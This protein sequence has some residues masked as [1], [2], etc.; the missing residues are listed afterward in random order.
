MRLSVDAN[1]TTV[2]PL[3]ES[4]PLHGFEFPVH[5]IAVRPV[6]FSIQQGSSV[7]TSE[8]D[9]NSVRVRIFVIS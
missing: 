9:L 5:T 7:N 4:T 2:I 1:V 6:R 8:A 3:N